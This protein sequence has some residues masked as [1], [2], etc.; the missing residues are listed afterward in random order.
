MSKSIYVHYNHILIKVK[1]KQFFLYTNMHKN[2][3]EG[4]EPPLDVEMGGWMSRG[5]RLSFSYFCII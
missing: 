1:Q 5:W 4:S 3:S 2:Q